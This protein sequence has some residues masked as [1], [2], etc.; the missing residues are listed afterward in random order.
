MRKIKFMFAGVGAIVLILSL[1]LSVQAD[2]SLEGGDKA[3]CYSTYSTGGNNV[4][5][6]CGT[7]QS[8][9]NVDSYSDSGT[10]RP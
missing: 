9:N 7:C 5:F 3:T 10:C 2:E 8:V 4:I 1:S 6:R